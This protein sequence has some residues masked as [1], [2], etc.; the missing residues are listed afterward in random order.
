MQLFLYW[1]YFVSVAHVYYK[2]GTKKRILLRLF[3]TILQTLDTYVT[4][5]I[6]RYKVLRTFFKPFKL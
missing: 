5:L 4:L 2:P 6:S 3:G 1:R